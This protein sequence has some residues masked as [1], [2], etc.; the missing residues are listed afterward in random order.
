MWNHE[1][2]AQSLQIHELQLHIKQH[3][4]H[5]TILYLTFLQPIEMAQIIAKAQL[6]QATHFS[7]VLLGKKQ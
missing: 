2:V 4:T 6:L 5:R 7:K 3:P 1:N